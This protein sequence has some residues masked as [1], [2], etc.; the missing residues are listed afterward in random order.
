MHRQSPDVGPLLHF[1]VD[2]RGKFAPMHFAAP[3]EQTQRLVFG[4]LKLQELQDFGYL[5]EQRSCTGV[6]L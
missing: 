6:T 5:P 1:V 4:H 2:L 3:T